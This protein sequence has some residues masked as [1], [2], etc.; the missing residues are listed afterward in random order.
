MN[1]NTNSKSRMVP[2]GHQLEPRVG[3]F[4]DLI[5]NK[6]KMMVKTNHFVRDLAKDLKQPVSYYAGAV[7]N[8]LW[9]SRL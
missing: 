6:P 1:S 7:W 2:K 8:K 3:G 4:S 5:K 9:L